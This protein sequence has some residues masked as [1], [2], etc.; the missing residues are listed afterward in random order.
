MPEHFLDED[1][2]RD[3]IAEAYH[4]LDQK[5]LRATGETIAQAASEKA[6]FR[7][8]SG[9]VRPKD[10]APSVTFTVQT[11]TG[12]AAS[13]ARD[14]L[15]RLSAQVRLIRREQ[16]PLRDEVM[17]LPD[18][19]KRRLQDTN[20]PLTLGQCI[21][22]R[23]GRDGSLGCFVEVDGAR[24]IL[25]ASHVIAKAGLIES[26]MMPER[27]HIYQPG[28]G[29]AAAKRDH[30]V[31]R[32]SEYF[33][34][35]RAAGATNTTDGAIAFLTTDRQ[36]T[37]ENTIPVGL[38]FPHEGEQIQG[39]TDLGDVSTGDRVFKIGQTTGLTFGTVSGLGERANDVKVSEVGSCSFVNFVKVQWD[40]GK[41]FA[42]SGD[43]GAVYI[44]E[45]NMTALAIHITSYPIRSELKIGNDSNLLEIPFK[46]K[47]NHSLGC[48]IQAFR[49][50]FA[51]E[52]L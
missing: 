15:R 4:E 51:F 29:Y 23:Q 35:I 44:L 6:S 46:R 33:S 16:A 13:V 28:C 11:K 49:E 1:Q 27:N 42:A 43:S 31:G 40:D 8:D 37:A 41:V 9:I 7:L 39:I 34:E 47:Q 25:S 3:V 5:S 50:E 12:P 30:V 10:A 18:N 22:H 20:Q 36:N 2:L 14:F 52:L 38:G 26:P 21:S 17:T 48:P 32:L 19:V 24:A 45:K